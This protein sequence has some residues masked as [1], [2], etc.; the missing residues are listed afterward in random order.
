MSGEPQASRLL[1]KLYR[2]RLFTDRRM[3]VAADR[4]ARPGNEVL[5]ATYQY[6]PL[7]RA[8]LLD[9]G[10]LAW[11]AEIRERWL[12]NAVSLLEVSGQMA[13]AI[14][15]LVGT[16]MSRAAELRRSSPQSYRAG[17]LADPARLAARATRAAAA[18]SPQTGVLVGRLLAGRRPGR[19]AQAARALACADAGGWRRRR[20]A[21][22]AAGVID[23]HHYQW[24]SFREMDRWI[25]A[26]QTL[27]ESRPC[28][29]PSKP[30]C[31]SIRASLLPCPAARQSVATSMRGAGD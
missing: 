2:E 3:V 28:S 26:I 11:T 6:H 13:D 1:E 27:L 23:S 4:D 19:C 20:A 14:T 25:A 10:R 29:T 12:L 8:F 18:G 9:R 17:P 15:I 22:V 24:A 21:A 31:T 5:V 30:S 7:F 16:G